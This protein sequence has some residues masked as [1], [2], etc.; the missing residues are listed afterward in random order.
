MVSNIVVTLLPKDNNTEES[1][2][3]CEEPKDDGGNG[4]DQGGSAKTQADFE[5]I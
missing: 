3:R 5:A 2:K 4:V 1:A